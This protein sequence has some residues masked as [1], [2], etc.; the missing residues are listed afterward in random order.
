MAAAYNKAL[1]RKMTTTT[2][3]PAD[4][5]LISQGAEAVRHDATRLYM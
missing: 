3:T 4:W 5:T 2:T 1:E